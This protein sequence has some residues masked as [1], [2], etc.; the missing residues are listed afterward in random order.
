[1]ML[2]Y[3]VFNMLNFQFPI[4]TYACE[5]T[6][7]IVFRE[8]RKKVKQVKYYLVIFNWERKDILKMVLDTV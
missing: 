6:N 3:N 2:G 4:M 8:L 7:A 1:M 5:R